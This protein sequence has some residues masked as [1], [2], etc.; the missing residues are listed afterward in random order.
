ML[1]EKMTVQDVRQVIQDFMGL[2]ETEFVAV[3]EVIADLKHQRAR[4]ARRAQVAE[5]AAQVR[6]RAAELKKLPRAELAAQFEASLEL[7]R[8]EAQAKGITTDDEAD[9][10]KDD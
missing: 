2:P 3:A 8:A 10:V 6:Q 1:N 7:L 9:W 4:A 5:L